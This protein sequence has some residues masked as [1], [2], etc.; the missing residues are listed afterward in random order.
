MVRMAPPNTLAL[1][2]RDRAIGDG[3]G[4]AV[5]NAAA[6]FGAIFRDCAAC[7]DHCRARVHKDTAPTKAGVVS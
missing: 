6:A 5:C 4:T 1:F 3:Q 2:S 7:D